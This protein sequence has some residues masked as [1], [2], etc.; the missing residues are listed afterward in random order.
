MSQTLE[1]T[2]LVRSLRNGSKTERKENAWLSCVGRRTTEPLVVRNLQDRALDDL[3][4]PG[5]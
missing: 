4:F 5:L 1:W 2:V 3:I